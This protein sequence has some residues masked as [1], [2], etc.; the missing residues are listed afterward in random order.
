M[1]TQNKEMLLERLGNGVDGQKYALLVG[2]GFNKFQFTHNG[3]HEPDDCDWKAILRKIADA[4]KVKNLASEKP[5]LTE[6]INRILDM[7]G[8]HSAERGIFLFDLMAEYG[9]SRDDRGGII[10][11]VFKPFTISSGKGSFQPCN[12]LNLA[13]ENG[14]HIL[15][16]NFDSNLE[17]Y[18]KAVYGV[19]LKQHRIPHPTKKKSSKTT[20][21]DGMETSSRKGKRFWEPCQFQWNTYYGEKD[22]SSWKT[23][24]HDIW[25]V[26]GNVI[27]K[28]VTSVLFSSEDYFNAISHFRHISGNPFSE[29][30]KGTY[31]WLKL[32]MEYPLVIVGLN[33]DA[34]E[35]LLRHLLMLRRKY[36]RMQEIDDAAS[37]SYFL[38][39]LQEKAAD[40]AKA[41]DPKN[42]F[43]ELMGFKSVAFDTFD[44]MYDL[45]C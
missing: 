3:M 7:P 2:N 44:E 41:S 36:R 38:Y 45:I 17:D 23:L 25:H 1:D 40:G 4:E 43:L 11:S 8:I 6:K 27:Q 37:P 9:L 26:H 39:S 21:L 12:L 42:P 14:H 18:F 35:L 5:E 16:T 31:S 32:F 29:D 19:L 24:S 33:L 20:P 22:A 10:K 13:W 34:G 28:A 15:T 30:W